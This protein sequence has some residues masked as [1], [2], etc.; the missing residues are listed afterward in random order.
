[1]EFL[2]GAAARNS[3]DDAS[4]SARRRRDT[5]AEGALHLAGSLYALANRPRNNGGSRF[6]L[7]RSS[8]GSRIQRFFYPITSAPCLRRE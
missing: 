6:I 5:Y 2:L 8:R 3:L 7:A 1:M 4:E